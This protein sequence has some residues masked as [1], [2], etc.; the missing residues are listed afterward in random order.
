MVLAANQIA[1]TTQEAV[2]ET[3]NVSAASQEQSASMQEIASSSQA[4]SKLA[5]KLQNVVNFLKY[6]NKKRTNRLSIRISMFNL[7]VRYFI[8]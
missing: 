2:S 4:L 3:Q 7:F 1:S 6:K 5:E 8:N